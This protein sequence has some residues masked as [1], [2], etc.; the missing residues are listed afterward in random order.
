VTARPPDESLRLPFG[1]LLKRFR[2]DAGMSQEV[3]AEKAR[4]SPETI[5]ALERGKRKAPQRETLALI[6]AALE[7]SPQQRAELEGAAQASRPLGRP[8]PINRETGIGGAFMVPHNLPH[9]ANSFHGRE[10]ELSEL[11]D[12]LRARRA[13]TLVG[14]GGVGK[15]RLALE[16][17]RSHVRKSLFPDGVWFVE[18]GSIEDPSLVTASFATTLQIRELPDESLLQTLVAELRNCRSLIVV[19]N[20]E[21]LLGRFA[22]VVGRLLQTCEWLGIMST[23]REALNIEGEL[24]YHVDPLNL[25]S[26][27]TSQESA[28]A[29]AE[30]T[31]TFETLQT[32]SAAQLFIARAADTAPRSFPSAAIADPV[33]VAKICERLDGLPLALELAAARV[34]D[35]SLRQILDGLDDRFA[36][37]KRGRRSAQPRQQTL[38][39]MLGWSYET[40]SISERR[41]FRW[42]GIFAAAW[43]L[44]S[45]LSLCTHLEPPNS[46]TASEL[47]DGIEALVS[48][49]L[50]AV[51]HSDGQRARYRLLETMRLY[52]RELL[53]SNNEHDAVAK[54]HAEF[55]RDFVG[56]A[57]R[58]SLVGPAAAADEAL[59]VIVS[60]MYDLHSAIDWTLEKRKDAVLGLEIVGAL[61][62]VWSA[63][64]VND[65]DVK[66]ASAEEPAFRN[67]AAQESAVPMKFGIA[68][69]VEL[70]RTTGNSREA[71]SAA[72]AQASVLELNWRHTLAT[73]RTYRA[74]EHIFRKGDVA[75]ELFYIVSGGVSLEEFGARIGQNDLLGEVA[76]FLPEKRRTAS[77]LCLTNVVVLCVEERNILKLFEREPTFCIDVLHVFAKRMIEDLKRYKNV[78]S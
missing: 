6:V 28:T 76:F 60:N 77:A 55:C 13:I 10:R 50:V 2:V 26:S 4:I 31:P 34:Y 51:E 24:L 25:V 38:V 61:F 42:L 67:A 8:K 11:A 64:A 73:E 33:S 9:A 48:K 7:L 71:S 59:D 65:R 32:S 5:G 27:A 47:R 74:G 16:V 72:D 41:L 63:S 75:S 40:L 69:M 14:A 54:R 66:H 35:L 62:G 43:R 68:G 20:C 22:L 3:L 1:A 46:P 30:Q 29:S 52:A 58:L 15:T 36:F 70:C 45:A 23:S 17:A 21:H 44:E 78:Y 49:S 56:E 12:L 18:L 39:G 37:L 57:Q 19:D 53:R